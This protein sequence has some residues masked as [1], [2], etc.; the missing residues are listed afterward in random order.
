MLVSCYSEGLST[1]SLWRT[2]MV[3]MIQRAD[4]E[5]PRRC[6]NF[7]ILRGGD[8]MTSERKM[9]IIGG[10]LAIVGIVAAGLNRKH[11]TPLQEDLPLPAKA[12][13]ELNAA[14]VASANK[15]NEH[16]PRMMDD[17]TRRGLEIGDDEIDIP[18]FLK[19]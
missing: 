9:Q 19:E 4:D 16:A 6:Y 18:E 12:Q 13:D 11:T 2:P 15:L 5:Q 3:R 1:L 10:V 14:L 8:A 7:C 17:R